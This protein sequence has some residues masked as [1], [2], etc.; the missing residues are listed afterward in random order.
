M[1]R[2]VKE[3]E[4]DLL[5]YKLIVC[6]SGT[7]LL[8]FPLSLSHPPRPPTLFYSTTVI[9]TDVP[10]TG[11]E[12]TIPSRYPQ[13]T[14]IR[15][16]SSFLWKYL[17]YISVVLLLPG[18]QSSM[19]SHLE[20]IFNG[21][22]VNPPSWKCDEHPRAR[23]AVPFTRIEHAYLGVTEQFMLYGPT[24]LNRLEKNMNSWTLQP[25]M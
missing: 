16:A 18:T 8:L 13:E 20:F 19:L 10:V 4:D 14:L 2:K 23:V 21:F 3:E 24:H 15:K 11:L 22:N 17:E 6:C 9:T 5:L 7:M 25:R 12:A 1:A